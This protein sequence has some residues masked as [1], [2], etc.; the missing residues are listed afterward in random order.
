MLQHRY[1]QTLLETAVFLIAPQITATFGAIISGRLTARWGCARVA[2]I[3][4]LVAS[5]FS[6][7]ALAVSAESS[8]WWLVALLSVIAIPIG[9][10][11]GPI[12]QT[13]MELAPSDGV[14]SA[15]SFRNS[16]VNLGIAIG[17]LAVSTV[18]FEEIDADTSRNI[19]AYRLQADAFHLAG[20]ICAVAYFVAAAFLM[21]HTKRRR[22]S[23]M[24]AL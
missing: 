6:L 12:T 22:E 3:A 5:L 2:F 17:G 24:L 14:A 23:T 21:L 1:H 8:A 9:A 15:S 20:Y 16:A 4:L 11:V 13:F 19:E 18:I 10:G 7:S